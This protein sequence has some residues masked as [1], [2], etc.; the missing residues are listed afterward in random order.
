MSKRFSKGLRKY[1][2]QEKARLRRE[3]LDY[4]TQKKLFQELYRK[5]NISKI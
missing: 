2:R 4:N 3:S 5:F 1:I